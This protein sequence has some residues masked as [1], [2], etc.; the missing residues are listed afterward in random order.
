MKDAPDSNWEPDP[1]LLAAYFD[2]ELESRHDLADVRARLEAWLEQHPQAADDSTQLQKLWLSTTPAEPGAVAWNQTLEQIDAN[3]K[4]PIAIPPRQRPWLAVAIVA[5]SILVFVGLLFG[6]WRSLAPTPLKSEPLAVRPIEPPGKV[7]DEVLQVATADEVVILRIE[8]RDTNAVV[9]GTLPVRGLLEMAVP[10]EVRVFH[11]RP[12]ATDNMVP[13][14]HQS[15]PH[16]PMIW[17]KLE[18]E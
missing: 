10:G 14:V 6:A 3:R 8:G 15:G 4:Q 9:V 2:G 16:A 17:A 12:A 18:T 13:T 7:D 5:A 11:A 1:Q